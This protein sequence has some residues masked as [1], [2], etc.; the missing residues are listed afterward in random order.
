MKLKAVI[1]FLMVASLSC[2]LEASVPL[3]DVCV[4]NFKLGV[5]TNSQIAGFQEAVLTEFADEF[6]YRPKF[7]KA[8][9]GGLQLMGP[10][11]LVVGFMGY[12]LRE[13]G[14]RL[15]LGL[16]DITFSKRKLSELLLSEALR[17]NPKIKMITTSFDRQTNYRVFNEGVESGL[18]KR[19]A[20][21]RTPSA[22]RMMRFGFVLDQSRPPNYKDHSYSFTRP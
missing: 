6:G 22:R 21:L 11:G 20:L 5:I 10:K 12:T 13:G 17:R 3:S 2:H 18:S 16:T 19:E 7:V 14:T 4:S 15:D 1:F 9:F 8:P